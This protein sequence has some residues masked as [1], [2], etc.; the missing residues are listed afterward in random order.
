MPLKNLGHPTPLLPHFEAVKPAIAPTMGTLRGAAGLA[1][2]SSNMPLPLELFYM[3]DTTQLRRYNIAMA[4]AF[5]EGAFV[6]G[7]PQSRANN[8]G[9]C[10][11]N[12]ALASFVDSATGRAYLLDRVAAWL[13]GADAN[14]QAHSTWSQL[15]AWKLRENGRAGSD[16]DVMTWALSVGFMLGVMP[17]S[18]IAA[19]QDQPPTVRV[20]KG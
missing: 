5:A 7:D 9:G 6:P 4:V 14:V 8:P 3:T 17:D 20:E 1:C 2:Y 12:G 13:N 11:E 10:F 15:A 19:Y 18:T 16:A